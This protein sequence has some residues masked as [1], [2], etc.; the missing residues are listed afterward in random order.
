[1]NNEHEPS[2]RLTKATPTP[3]KLPQLQL[4]YLAIQYFELAQ[5]N[6]LVSNLSKQPCASRS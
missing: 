6:Q 5:H 3:L 2:Q 4:Q 1:M